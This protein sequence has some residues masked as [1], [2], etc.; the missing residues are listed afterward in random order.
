M[1]TP[2]HIMIGSLNGNWTINRS[3]T[4]E[5]D[6]ILK[7]QGIPWLLRKALAVVTVHINITTYETNESETGK[8]I[9]NIDCNQTTSGRLA[10]TT[11][12]RRL[13]WENKEHE[14]Y[15]FG[16]VQGRSEFVHGAPDK[17]GHVRPEFELQ[18]DVDD[19]Q[20]IKRF[21]RGETHIDS[22]DGAG[23]LCEESNGAW[24]HTFERSVSSGWASEQIWGFELIDN[25]RYFTRRAAVVDAG[26]RCLCVRLVLDYEQPQ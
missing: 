3:L 25:K 13:T 16:K 14:D 11:E 9:T 23:F 20:E 1:A 10:G 26:G 7:L 8:P 24:V 12:K 19:A 15:F 17:G 6:H 2:A 21:L 18:I 4:G 5:T 22:R